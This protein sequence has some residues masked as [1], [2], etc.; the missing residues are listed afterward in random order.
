MI[1]TKS[2][3]DCVLLTLVER[4]SRNT[5]I[6]QISSKSTEDV[7]QELTSICEYFGDKFS[8]VFKTITTDNGSEFS[9]LSSIGADMVTRVYFTHPYSSFERGTK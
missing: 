8:P 3:S 1:G 7:I 2:S 6:Y 4:Q 5:I 9:D